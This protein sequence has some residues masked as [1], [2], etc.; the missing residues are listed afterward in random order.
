M[1]ALFLLLALLNGARAEDEDQSKVNIIIDQIILAS[2]KIQKNK[3]L[4]YLQPL[5]GQN[6]LQWIKHGLF[7]HPAHIY[8]RNNLKGY[9]STTFSHDSKFLLA[10]TF[11]D[12]TK[13]QKIFLKKKKSDLSEPDCSSVVGR[14]KKWNNKWVIY[15]GDYIVD[16]H[17][18]LE[19]NPEK[20]TPE[21]Y[22]NV[23]CKEFF[24]VQPDK[25]ILF[26]KDGSNYYFG[27]KK[28]EENYQLLSIGL[29]DDCDA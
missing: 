17:P 4:K 3:D 5:V 9:A 8:E 28:V 12:L 1:L 14:D 7:F 11:D 22:E 18:E 2:Q 29:D 27:I 13:S 26:F 15:P 16:Q 10:M 21:C 6:L 19:A 20:R 25:T 23:D 24:K